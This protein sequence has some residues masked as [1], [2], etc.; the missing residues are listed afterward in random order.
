MAHIASFG[1][2][3]WRFSSAV[4]IVIYRPK[5]TLRYKR[6]ENCLGGMI[7]THIGIAF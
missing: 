6:S 2:L 5:D 7:P 3:R 4:T 1:R